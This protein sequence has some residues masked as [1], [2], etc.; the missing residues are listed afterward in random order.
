MSALYAGPWGPLIVFG[1]RICDVSLTTMRTLLIVRGQRFLVPI[2]AVFETMIWLTAI[3]NALT[4]LDN[5]WLLAGYVLGFA[6]GNVV[7]MWLEEKLAVGVV[8]AHVFSR[9]EGKRVGAALRASGYRV[10]EIVGQGRD[11]AVTVLFCVTRRRDLDRLIEIARTEDPDAFVTVEE[12]RE[13]VQGRVFAA[14]RK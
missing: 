1:L 10:T 14:L 7:G 8:S 4:H 6:S 9:R 2:I 3:G 11:G 12:A 5:H 13:A